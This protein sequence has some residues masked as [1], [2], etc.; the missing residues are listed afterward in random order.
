[1]TDVIPFLC[2]LISDPKR[3]GAIVPSG[4]ALATAITR[5]ISPESAPVIELGPGTGA[6]TQR[7]LERG[8]PEDR[9]ALIEFGPDF[10]RLLAKR[11]SQ[12]LVLRMDATRLKH[13]ELF[14]DE[15][16]GA[17]VSGIPLLSMSPRQIIAILLGAFHHLRPGGAFYQFTYGPTCPVPRAILDRLDLKA[18]RIGRAIVNVPPANVYRITRKPSSPSRGLVSP[19]ELRRAHQAA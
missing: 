11:Y 14:E 7:L 6:F 9:L 18:K 8:V 4:A 17:V 19:I 3:V 13:V 10:A 1:M 12:A 5:E 2:A 16:A 15:K